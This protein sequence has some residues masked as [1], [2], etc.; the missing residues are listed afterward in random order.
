M[1]R[2]AMALGLVAA[3]MMACTPV[4]AS[5]DPP[6]RDPEPDPE[7]RPDTPVGIPQPA[8]AAA[9]PDRVSLEDDSP[10]YFPEWRKL[11]VRFNG[12]ECASVVEFC[13][14]EGWTR[15]QIFHGGRPKMERGKF[16]TVTRRGTV[17]P[18]WR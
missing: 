2:N 15:S 5:D 12:G 17:E 11:G 18:Y 4:A 10:F 7:P 16:V 6:R 8:A 14:S 1:R 3:S 9:I 13:V